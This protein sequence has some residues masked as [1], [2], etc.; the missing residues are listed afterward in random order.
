MLKLLVSCPKPFRSAFAGQPVGSFKPNTHAE[1]CCRAVCELPLGPIARSST[2]HGW[3]SAGVLPCLYVGAAVSARG[4]CRVYTWVLLCLYV[5]AA[6]SIRGCCR[7]YTWVLLCLYVGAA[8][9]IG[10]LWFIVR[11]ASVVALPVGG[12]SLCRF[13]VGLP[14]EAWNSCSFSWRPLGTLAGT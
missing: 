12:L 8:S 9:K 4:C 5:G 10:A 14:V 1:L 7:V 11:V 2:S 6:V 3:M 13:C